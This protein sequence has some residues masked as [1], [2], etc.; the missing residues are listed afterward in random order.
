LIDYTSQILKL[1]TIAVQRL[2]E[3][4]EKF[5]F[6]GKNLGQ[7][8][9][10][11]DYISSKGMCNL[12]D[13]AETMALTASTAT[14]QV[15]KLFK[16]GLIER[17]HSSNDRRRVDLTLTE[18][19]EKANKQFYDYRMKNLLPLLESLTEHESKVLIKLLE[20]VV[21]KL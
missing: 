16:L 14:R 2:T 3:Q 15:D 18:D 8:I 21:K 6:K 12:K 10:I 19:G 17:K 13:I 1:L 11:I 5:T 4:I 20:N 9:F 7:G